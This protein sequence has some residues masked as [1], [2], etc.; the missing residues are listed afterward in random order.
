MN[1]FSG[2]C[3]SQT[4]RRPTGHP[5][6]SLQPTRP[7]ECGCIWLREKIGPCKCNFLWL[8]QF[9]VICVKNVLYD[10]L[11]KWVCFYIYDMLLLG[12]WFVLYSIDIRFNASL[13]HSFT[14]LSPHL[15]IYPFIYSFSFPFIPY[16][17]VQ[18]WLVLTLWYS[19]CC[20]Y[21]YYFII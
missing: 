4:E 7:V 8:W 14:D 15:T 11:C 19:L 20:S 3:H 2:G 17:F 12:I 21:G 10:V 6:I 1:H 9:K 18:I 16:L 13:I 5:I